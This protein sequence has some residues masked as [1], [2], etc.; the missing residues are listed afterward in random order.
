MEDKCIIDFFGNE[1]RVG[2]K[3]VCSNQRASLCFGEVIRIGNAGTTVDIKIIFAPFDRYWK[4]AAS[5]ISTIKK[6]VKVLSN[7]E[8]YRN[9]KKDGKF[10]TDTIMTT[11]VY[12]VKYDFPNHDSQYKILKTKER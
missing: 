2:D 12:C 11:Y 3:V 1:I 4:N 9:Y 10:M 6:N 8:E 7:K 5:R